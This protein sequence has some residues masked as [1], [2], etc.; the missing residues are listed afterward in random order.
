[1][2]T[3][4][5][6]RY[7]QVVVNQHGQ[8]GVWPLADAVPGGWSPIGFV[9]TREECL[10]QVAELWRDMRPAG[11]TD[12]RPA[13]WIGRITAAADA[14]PHAVALRGGGERLTYGEL[15]ADARRL[16]GRLSAL[17]V[18][19]ETRVALYL[20]LGAAALTALLGVAVTGAAYLPIDAADDP[21]R[22]DLMIADSG[23]RAVVTGR[24]E[25]L[26]HT[27]AHLV[28]WP[29]GAAGAGAA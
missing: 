11:R 29:D 20:P 10:V 3:G 2:T 28:T 13:D 7:F 16:A 14:R 17:G 12:G 9:S 5:P 24:P 25:T 23:A 18:G 6:Q 22:R 15:V 21:G 4:A 26:A 27:D 8:Y 1:M 19:A